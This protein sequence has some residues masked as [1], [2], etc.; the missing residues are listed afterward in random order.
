[1]SLEEAE[2]RL[3]AH[4]I[5]PI[6]ALNDANQNTTA[7]DQGNAKRGLHELTLERIDL[8]RQILPG[9]QQYG[10]RGYGHQNPLAPWPYDPTEKGG[11]LARYLHPE[12]GPRLNG[13]FANLANLPA[14][15]ET[16]AEYADTIMA[17]R[18][19]VLVSL[20]Q[21]RKGLIAHFRSD[22]PVRILGK[23]LDPRAW[24]QATRML[25][26]LP[27]L[28]QSAVDDWGFS[29]EGQDRTGETALAAEAGGAGMQRAR[30]N[31]ILDQHRP[32]LEA[33]R[34]CLSPL[35]NFFRQANGP[36]TLNSFL[37]R[38]NSDEQRQRYLEVAAEQGIPT[39]KSFLSTYNFAEA[40]R[41]LPV[42]QKEFR[43]RFSRLIPQARLD[44]LEREESDVMNAAWALWYSFVEQPERQWRAPETR[45]YQVFSDILERIRDGIRTGFAALP[46]HEMRARIESE[47]LEWD[48]L[49]ALCL[50]VQVANPIQ[51]HEAIRAVADV[52]QSTLGDIVIRSAEQFA[53]ETNWP[54]ILV[55]PTFKGMNPA[56]ALWRFRPF[57]F[58]PDRN[59]HENP[60]TWFPLPFPSD[61]ARE[62][63]VELRDDGV[64]AP[65]K[66]LQLGVAEFWSLLAH[67]SDLLRIPDPVDDEGG[68][69][70]QKY[71]GGVADR[72]SAALTRAAELWLDAIEDVRSTDGWMDRPLLAEIHDGLLDLKDGLM[73]VADYTPGDVIELQQLAAWAD[74]LQPLLALPEAM[75]LARIADAHGIG[76]V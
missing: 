43:A 73:P 8:L 24:D 3:F 1:M 74:R 38:A 68:A 70:L 49:P 60:A 55:V 23:Y 58:Y 54:N 61:V 18:Q 48:G 66:R 56:A 17:A 10:T 33:T 37:G 11:V 15:P 76:A 59:I 45:A 53:V 42:F 20:S 9:R 5:V 40:R 27:K 75:R 71:M 28:P 72:I 2:D 31:L 36:L 47:A 35:E 7:E 4:F 63:G 50:V 12:W 46:A 30:A 41:H 64:E 69:L 26:R 44:R 57:S 52:L 32:L 25:D 65:L 6:D 34:E 39:E 14:R 21:L 13:T 22:K 51:T 67:V 19:A 16:W 62:M 29:S